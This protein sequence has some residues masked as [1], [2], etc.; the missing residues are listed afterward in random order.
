MSK[1]TREYLTVKEEV[2]TKDL[3][4]VEAAEDLLDEILHRYMHTDFKLT[5]SKVPQAPN[6]DWWYYCKVSA[7]TKLGTPNAVIHNYII[8]IHK[9]RTLE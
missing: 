2:I 6:T 9:L 3:D 4:Y 5:I 7:S 1:V 8:R